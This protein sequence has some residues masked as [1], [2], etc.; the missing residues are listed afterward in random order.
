RNTEPGSRLA[1]KRKRGPGNQ[2]QKSQCPNA[3]DALELK[4]TV[5]WQ[6]VIRHS[7]LAGCETTSKINAKVWKSRVF[8]ECFS[9]VSRANLERYSSDTRAIFE[10]YSS[11][12][13]DLSDTSPVHLRSGLE[14]DSCL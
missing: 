6:P 10:R 12:T 3:A 7:C 14:G 8:L 11:D 4:Q 2:E 9:S 13:R 5:D 1:A